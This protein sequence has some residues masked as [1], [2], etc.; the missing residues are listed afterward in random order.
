M[1][2]DPPR[3][4]AEKYDDVELAPHPH[5]ASHFFLEHTSGWSLFITI[6]LL[7]AFMGM[8]GSAA[9]KSP[10]ILSSKE[11]YYKL[12][13]T[14]GNVSVDIEITLS[15]LQDGHRF[16]S[17]NGSFVTNNTSRSRTLPVELNV[18]KM[19]QKNY[20]TVQSNMNEGRKRFDISFTP[21]NN[22]SNWF[23]VVQ[24]PISGVDTL[25]LRLTLT[26]TYDHI[27][28]FCFRWD[29]QN[30]SA[31]KYEQSAKL[32]MSFLVGYMLVVFA[33]YLKFDAESFSQI[34]LLILGVTGVFASNPL[35]YFLKAKQ[36]ARITDHILMAVF[37]AVFRLFL[38]IQ[39]EL[40][41]THSQTPA[42]VL[43]IVLCIFFGFYA[44][45]DAAA[46]YDRNAHVLHAQS[47][48]KGLFQTEV[49]AIAFNILYAIGAVAYFI[50]SAIA[51]EGAN[52]RRVVFL[53]VSIFAV[54]LSTV[55]PKVVFPITGAYMYSLLP[56]MLAS[57]THVTF[58][59][60]ALFLLHSGGG[61]EYKSI[62]DQAKA[63][64]EPVIVE[65]I[66]DGD[67]DSDDSDDE[68]EEG[69][70]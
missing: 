33:F 46:S 45:V 19:L 4:G 8:H 35:N 43:V 62:A 30:P 61:R 6:A 1:A 58:A 66:S 10:P 2:L 32:L 5:A 12:N 25:Q 49:A 42:K 37:T 9:L 57:W 67:D 70:S 52:L 48:V 3:A 36:G 14:E 22:R 11:E 26:T 38:V 69:G 15:Q 23:D 50:V 53:G 28:G 27:A 65:E 44:T 31:E 59:S 60:I 24:V 63:P 39:C 47:P 20:N 41:R 40:V 18:G 7:V 54:V 64:Q 56:E 55:V 51:N 68:E 29:F 13:S 16:I 21:G 34:F 17:V